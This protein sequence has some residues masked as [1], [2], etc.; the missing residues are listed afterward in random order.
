MREILVVLYDLLFILASFY[1]LL[2]YFLRGRINKEIFKRL[3]TPDLSSYLQDK[4]KP[5]WL[6]AVSVGEVASLEELINSLKRN[7]PQYPLLLSTI[8][9]QGKELGEKLY[10]DRVFIFYLP[11]DLSFIMKRVVSTI[12]PEIFIG[13]ETEIWPN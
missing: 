4:K 2:K 13:A 3:Q 7:F 6:H 8:T 5:I 11:L 9:S 10:K 1:F 12:S